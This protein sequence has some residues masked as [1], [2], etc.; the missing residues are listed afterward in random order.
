MSEPK[1]TT[2]RKSARSDADSNCVEVDTGPGQNTIGVRDTK[3]RNKGILR[4]TGRAWYDLITSVRAG[5]FRR[6]NRAER[7]LAGQGSRAFD[8]DAGELARESTEV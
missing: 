1:Y 3:D 6:L 2:W 4:F 7:L 5:R 8:S